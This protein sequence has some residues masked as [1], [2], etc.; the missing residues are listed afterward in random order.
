MNNITS[1]RRNIISVQEKQIFKNEGYGTAQMYLFI[2]KEFH[3]PK[4]GYHEELEET[5][6]F[7][8]ELIL[9]NRY[10]RIS[11]KILPAHLNYVYVLIE[12]QPLM[13]MQVTL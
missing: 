8:R 11:I 3:G 7:V 9:H 12:L 6:I 4:V 2:T 5:V 1:Q 10:E 13:L